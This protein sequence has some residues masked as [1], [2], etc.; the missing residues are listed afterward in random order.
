MAT[1]TL[2]EHSQAYVLQPEDG[3]LIENLGLRI[4]AS[5]TQTRDAFMAGVVTNPGPGGP[6]LHTHFTID[7][8]Y[9]VLQGR[10]RFKIRD[11]EYEG[12]PGTFVY[13]PRGTSHTFA[14]A[15]PEDGQLFCITL[16]GT[17][18][19]LRGISELQERGMDQ[20]EMVEHFHTFQTEIDGPPLV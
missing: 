18:D 15:G 2:P 12:G 1:A 4:L 10:Y 14:S 9:F 19:F 5:N 16:P 13:A 6:P 8:L 3:Q 11:Q 17:E 20:Q 7:E